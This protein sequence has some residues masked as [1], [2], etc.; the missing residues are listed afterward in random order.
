MKAIPILGLL[1]MLNLQPI[2]KLP[3]ICYIPV[4]APLISNTI[5]DRTY[6]NNY[7]MNNPFNIRRDD[8]N[9]WVGKVPDNTA[10]FESFDTMEH[11]I[12]AGLKLLQNY[13]GKF[14]LNTIRAIVYKFAPPIENRTTQYVEEVCRM[15][16][17]G[18]NK[19]LDLTDKDTL[20]KLASAIIYME[21]GT[22]I[23][24]LEKVYNQYFI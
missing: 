18:P 21:T 19:G 11:G 23:N 24:I 2:T 5:Q 9:K 1:M 16:G 3:E 7:N 13:Q 15:T 20:L 22:Y 17:F 12:R 6:I 14:G 4:S 10:S 8:N